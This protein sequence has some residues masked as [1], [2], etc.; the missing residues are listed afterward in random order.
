MFRLKDILLMLQSHPKCWLFIILE[1]TVL[2]GI[3]QPFNELTYRDMPREIAYSLLYTGC[4]MSTFYYGYGIVLLRTTGSCNDFL[5]RICG[6]SLKIWN[7]FSFLMMLPWSMKIYAQI[8]KISSCILSSINQH[9]NIHVIFGDI[10]LVSQLLLLWISLIFAI[11]HGY[12]MTTGL[13][14][15]QPRRNQELRAYAMALNRSLGFEM[16]RIP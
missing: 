10:I 4:A 3:I 8:D 14:I 13:R 16:I 9:P 1:S 2:L 12:N 7:T 15:N 5:C 6:A 11:I